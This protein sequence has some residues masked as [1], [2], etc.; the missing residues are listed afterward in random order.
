ML[1]SSA[2]TSATTVPVHVVP[3][4]PAGVYWAEGKQM[5]LVVV[6][7]PGGPAGPVRPCIPW[8]SMML[9]TPS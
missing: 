9:Y 4:M 7:G 2:R 8:Q 5:A 6:G 1:H 3:Q